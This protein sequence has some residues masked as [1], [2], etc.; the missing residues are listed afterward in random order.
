MIQAG[1][2]Y[3]YESHLNPATACQNKHRQG[4]VTVPTSTSLPAMYVYHHFIVMDNNEAAA[5]CMRQ[6]MCTADNHN[7]PSLYQLALPC[8]HIIS[9][10]YTTFPDTSASIMPPIPASHLSY[11]PYGIHTAAAAA[12][13]LHMD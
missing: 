11:L 10:A 1:R 6:N 7:T 4:G 9:A 3:I 13:A 5:A 2:V 8:P 12:A